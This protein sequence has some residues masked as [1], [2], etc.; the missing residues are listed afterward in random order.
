M[1]QANKLALDWFRWSRVA[2]LMRLR[3][4]QAAAAI[5]FL[6]YALLWSEKLKESLALQA[7]LGPG[8]GLWTDTSGRL[9]LLYLGSIL[10]TLAWAIYLFRCPRVIK[11]YDFVDDYLSRQ[12]QMND[13]VTMRRVLEIM[14]LCLTGDGRVAGS[15]K[16]KDNVPDTLKAEIMPNALS[17]WI[18]TPHD[19]EHKSGLFKSY[20]HL[21]DGSHPLWIKASLILFS[22]GSFIFLI[23]SL[24]IFLLVVRKMIF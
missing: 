22:L 18:S 2:Q 23:P 24:E 1:I 11:E 4:S 10:L 9:W 17:S 6:G 7:A 8:D 12:M 16:F 5:P 3:I 19:P 15:I 13:V 14:K 20:Y 21:V